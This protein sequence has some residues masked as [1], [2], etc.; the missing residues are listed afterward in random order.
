MARVL[1]TLQK[2]GAPLAD[3]AVQRARLADIP[4]PRSFADALRSAGL[5]PL[6][7]TQIEILQINVGKRCNQTCRHC[8]VDAGP[9]RTEVMPRAVIEA[10]LG[11]LQRAG[12]PTLDITGEI[13][14][15]HV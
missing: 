14:R 8:H 2:Q 1:P 7:P 13:G 15:A 6:R 12:I 3:G 9:D 11:F 5:Y 4:V 10:C